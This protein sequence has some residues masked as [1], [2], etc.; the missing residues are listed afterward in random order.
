MTGLLCSFLDNW[1]R[2]IQDGLGQTWIVVFLVAFMCIIVL[3]F[4]GILRSAL[5]TIKPRIEWGY[6]FLLVIFVL[7]FVWFCTLV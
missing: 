4:Y 3:L 1:G 5:V 7:F 2:S 6:I